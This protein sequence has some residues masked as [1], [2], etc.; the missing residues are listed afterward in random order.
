[1]KNHILICGLCLLNQVG[2]FSQIIDL[3]DTIINCD[4][5]CGLRIGCNI[6][7]MVKQNPEIQFKEDS[8]NKYGIDGWGNGILVKNGKDSLFFL[9]SKSDSISAIIILS[10]RITT[11]LGIHLGSKIFDC[12][13]KYKNFYLQR[14]FMDPGIEYYSIE[15]SDC[16]YQQIKFH[17][18]LEFFNNPK[19]EI[20]IYSSI[21]N[22]D[23]KTN[24]FTTYRKKVGSIIIYK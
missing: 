13:V 16:N 24:R 17:Y 5:I 7:N 12:V 8:V 19:N 15:D 4:N 3:N 9:C 10:K 21:S 22:E 23:E 14:N 11:S 18:L 1:M 2:L 6:K 20:G